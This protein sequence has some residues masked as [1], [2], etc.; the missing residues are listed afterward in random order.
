M[1]QLFDV[2]LTYTTGDIVTKAVDNV[3]IQISTGEFVGIVGP[4]GSGKSSLLYLMA[5]LK[6]PTSGWIFFHQQKI[7]DLSRDERASL[8]QHYFGFIFQQ[9]FLIQYLTA[10]ENVLVAIP[11]P[12][13]ADT[14]RA[15]ELLEQ[16]GLADHIK[17]FPHQLSGGQRQRVAAAR[18]LIHRP[19]VIFADEPTASLDHKTAFDLMNLIQQSRNEEQTALVVVTH[20][21]SVLDGADRIVSMWDGRIRHD[22]ALEIANQNGAVQETIEQGAA[23][24]SGT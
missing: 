13:K 7:G 24:T 4:S 11:K 19:A 3:N 18:A 12:S 8:R 22:P 1:L 15:H 5:G 14:A 21:P 9:H 23:E 10:L 2:S 16:L 17:K 20:D 6:D